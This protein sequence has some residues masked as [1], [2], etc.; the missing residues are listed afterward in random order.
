M[1]RSRDQATG[2]DLGG[3]LSAGVIKRADFTLFVPTHDD[4]LPTD[5]GGDVVAGRGISLEIAIARRHGRS[6]VVLGGAAMPSEAL[7]GWRFR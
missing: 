2:D 1:V 3:A 6:A 7:G 4:R 5:Y